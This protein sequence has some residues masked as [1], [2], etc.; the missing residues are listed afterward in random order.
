MARIPEPQKDETIMAETALTQIVKDGDTTV[1]VFGA[2]CKHIDELIVEQASREV[3][4]AV[5]A[6]APPQ[7][8]L[9]LS[10]TEFFGSSFIEVLFRAWNRLQQKPGGKL[11]LVGLGPYCREVLAITHLD[12]LWPMYDTREAALTAMK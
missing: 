1:V 4:D 3:M 5:L 2:K 11:S 9:D 8:I 12:K 6:A 7:V 10:V